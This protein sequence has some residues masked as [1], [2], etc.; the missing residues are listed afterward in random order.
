MAVCVL[1]L[2]GGVLKVFHLH[3]HLAAVLLFRLL[4]LRRL[5]QVM[6]VAL[7]WLFHDRVFDAVVLINMV[8]FNCRASF[9][10]SSLVEFRHDLFL[11][12]LFLSDLDCLIRF[13]LN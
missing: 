12:V 7:I 6:E 3:D 8:Q 10:P 2:L 13:I 5:D 11:S 4:G 1:L 9:G